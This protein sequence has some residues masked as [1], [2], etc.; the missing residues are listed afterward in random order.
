MG[1]EAKPEAKATGSA[2]L[3][4]LIGRDAPLSRMALTIAIVTASIVVALLTS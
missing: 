1:E 2:R 3:A 4:W